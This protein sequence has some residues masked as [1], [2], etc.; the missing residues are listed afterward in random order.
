M[1]IFVTMD[2]AFK[3]LNLALVL[4]ALVFVSSCK[5]PE[6]PE[7]PVDS[8]PKRDVITYRLTVVPNADI[9]THNNN[10]DTLQIKIN[11][12]SYVYSKGSVG[13][14]YGTTIPPLKTG[15]VV[16]VYYNPG[17]VVFNGKTMIDENGLSVYVDY[18]QNTSNLLLKEFKCRCIGVFETTLP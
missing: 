11:G 6:P 3:K 2:N 7:E 4:L 18:N 1:P 8:S 9:P 14:S 16:Y 13:E 17:K 12:V 15:D 5:K 10:G